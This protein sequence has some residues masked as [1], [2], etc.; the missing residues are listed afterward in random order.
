MGRHL[1]NSHKILSKKNVNKEEEEV[2]PSSIAN[3][4]HNGMPSISK[5]LSEMA[6][7]HYLE[8]KALLKESLLKT[9][10]VNLTTDCWTS[11]QNFSYIDLTDHYLDCN[12]NFT[13]VLLAIRHLICGHSSKNMEESISEILND[14]VL[15]EKTKNITTDN[16]SSMIQLAERL[17]LNRI[18]CIAHILH[19]IVKNTLKAIK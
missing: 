18:P 7:N 19:L 8:K 3:V 12:L 13:S 4:Y 10:I 15:K 9:K 14:F 11:V 5:K 16:A 17:Q 1:L 2:D 6:T